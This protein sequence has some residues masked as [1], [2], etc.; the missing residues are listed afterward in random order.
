MNMLFQIIL[1]LLILFV[2]NKYLRRDSLLFG[3]DSF[4]KEN[5]K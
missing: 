2:L 4:D 3:L 5:D 1:V